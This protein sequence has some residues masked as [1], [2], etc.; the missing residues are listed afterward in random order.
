MQQLFIGIIIIMIIASISD[1]KTKS[2][3]LWTV[4]A[5]DVAGLV[6]FFTKEGPGDLQILISDMF[7]LSIVLLLCLVLKDRGLSIGDG[8]LIT[9]LAGATNI[10]FFL[11]FISLAF[12]MSGGWSIL[13]LT[14]KRADKNTRI[15]FV[16]FLT[17]AV[18][19]LF[20]YR[21]GL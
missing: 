2:I 16:P 14:V 1:M 17:A 13:L 15:P 18:I 20:V 8:L 3:P 21:G 10:T 9:G 4:I 6:L 7:V 12:L 11:E 19:V 5:I